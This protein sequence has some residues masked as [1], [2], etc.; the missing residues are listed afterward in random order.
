MAWAGEGVNPGRRGPR[1][2]QELGAREV[3]VR[4][5]SQLVIRQLQ[6]TYAV[7]AASIWI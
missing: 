3:E 1:H 7:L 2:A 5:D 4:A 6:G